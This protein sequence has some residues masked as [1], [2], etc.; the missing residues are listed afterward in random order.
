MT[1]FLST[2]ACLSLLAL[3]SDTGEWIREDQGMFIFYYQAQ[4]QS[5][6]DE[7]KNMIAQGAAAVKS[8]FNR[9]F[10]KRFDVYVH[11]TRQSWDQKLQEAYKMPDFKSEC[12][13][14]A[15]GDGFQLNMISP[16]TWDT[17]A[18]EHRYADKEETQRLL[19]HELFHVFHGQQNVS[20]D[21]SDIEGLDWLAEGFATYASGQL[22]PKRAEGIRS[23]IASATAPTQL[24]DFWTG[25]HRYGLAGSMVQY[26]DAHYGR[27]V[28][29]KIL[30]FNKK[31]Q[32]LAALQVSEVEL[33]DGW[34]RMQ[35]GK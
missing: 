20:P 33:I 21:F 31:P 8:F 35:G 26:I 4:D 28:L 1:N 17:A 11:P 13:M 22:T 27:K 10:A 2:L 3:F 15:S 25:Q 9:P 19:T 29:F 14:V 18:C 5:H 24:D 32:V 12:W 34:R 7:Y 23:L 16:V 30:A 6:T